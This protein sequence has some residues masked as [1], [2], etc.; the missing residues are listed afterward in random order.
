MGTFFAIIMGSF[1]FAGV[2]T[3]LIGIKDSEGTLLYSLTFGLI[4][5]AIAVTALFLAVK[6]HYH[7]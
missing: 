4:C 7:R 2:Y 3:S 1:G 6:L 5:L